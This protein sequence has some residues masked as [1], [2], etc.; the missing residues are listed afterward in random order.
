MTRAR[1]G[2]SSMILKTTLRML[3]EVRNGSAKVAMK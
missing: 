1:G 2:T 3:A